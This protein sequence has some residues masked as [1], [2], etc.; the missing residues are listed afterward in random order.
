MSYSVNVDHGE[1]LHGSELANL[2]L[3]TSMYPVN[4]MN[5][6][7]VLFGG[8]LTYRK[9]VWVSQV[10]WTFCSQSALP[11]VSE[12]TVLQNH[13]F[14]SDHAALKL[15]LNIPSTDPELIPRS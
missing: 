15:M 3:S 13:P 8:G 14:S 2:L 7:G 10:D 1:N 11:Y 5:L 12:F 4:H 9:D 6:D